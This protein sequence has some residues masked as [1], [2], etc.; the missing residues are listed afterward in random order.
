MSPREELP[1]DVRLSS[2]CDSVRA[3]CA[4][5]DALRVE[6]QPTPALAGV[7]YAH[8]FVPGIAPAQWLAEWDAIAREID[9]SL[10]HAARVASADDY[11]L[12]AARARR[13]SHHATVVRA[14]LANV[15]LEAA[16]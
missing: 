15:K 8:A 10:H 9:A 14:L 1:L 2:L 7:V 12:A 5:D 13:W 6:M 4:P 3:L 16:R 11:A